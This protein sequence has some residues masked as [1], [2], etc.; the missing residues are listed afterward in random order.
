METLQLGELLGELE[1]N[2]A[3]DIIWNKTNELI[4]N[5]L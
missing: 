5:Y 3:S 2:G 1:Q 4:G